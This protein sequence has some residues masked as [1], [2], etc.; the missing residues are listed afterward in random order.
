[1]GAQQQ[2]IGVAADALRGLRGDEQRWTAQG[3]YGGWDQ[4]VPSIAPDALL[5][6]GRY[7]AQP[8]LTDTVAFTSVLAAPQVPA[9]DAP[10]P[11]LPLALMGLDVVASQDLGWL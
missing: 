8:E 1:M 9:D 4:R 7:V 11:W 5:P 3:V 6:G 10:E 2:E